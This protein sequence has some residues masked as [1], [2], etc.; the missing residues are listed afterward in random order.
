MAHRL[1]LR[2]AFVR[3]ESEQNSSLQLPQGA[4]VEVLQFSPLG[5]S[6]DQLL[7]THP[8]HVIGGDSDTSASIKRCEFVPFALAACLAAAVS[9]TKVIVTIGLAEIVAS[10]CESADMQMID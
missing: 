9:T 7:C 1:V 10:A 8:C 5:C 4:A 3:R 6:L 2:Y